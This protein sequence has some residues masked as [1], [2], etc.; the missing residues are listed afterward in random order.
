[1]PFFAI[2]QYYYYYKH[3]SILL[4]KYQSIMQI[5]FYFIFSFL[6]LRTK[7]FLDT[8]FR[9]T[10]IFLVLFKFYT[11]SKVTK[12]FGNVVYGGKALLKIVLYTNNFYIPIVN[13]CF[14]DS[15]ASLINTNVFWSYIWCTQTMLLNNIWI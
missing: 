2:F 14:M 1:M 4:I 3:Y 5:R 13:I 12:F 9:K 7:N 15:Y 11:C 6:V 8:I 10:K